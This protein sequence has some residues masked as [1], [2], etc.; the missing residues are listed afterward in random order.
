MYLSIPFK[1]FLDLL[2]GTLSFS[3]GKSM[4][5]PEE[6]LENRSQ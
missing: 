2:A 6:D 5:I 4:K 3:E 1:K